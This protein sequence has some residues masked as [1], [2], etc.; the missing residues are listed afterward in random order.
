MKNYS[1]KYISV[2]VI[3]GVLFI[4]WGVL[5]L[6]DA[7]NYTYDGYYT[8]DNWEVIKVE[9]GSPAEISG[10]QLGD[11]I[12]STGG[13]AV[14]DTK[15]LNNR[16]RAEIGETREI[17]VDRNGEELKL[18]L[19][20]SKML[21]KDKTNNTVGFILGLIFILF[22][23][24]AS[25]KHKTSLS[26]S[27]GV[28]AVCFGFL[29][30]NGPYIASN[31]LSS[32]IGVISSVVFLFAFTAL[33]IYML[34]YPP[35]SS[36]LSSKNSKLLYIP[37]L[38][39]LLIIIGLEVIQPD[40]S[41]TLNMVMRLLFGVFIIGYFLIAL[42]TLIKKYSKAS[43]EEKSSNGLNLMLWGVIIGIV[44]ILIEFTIRTISPATEI[45][46]SDYL[47]YTFAAMPI[48]FTL[49]LS[50]LYANKTES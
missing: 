8:D 44:P 37:M 49:A 21:D 7:K 50:K 4:I 40:R 30:M 12:K 38:I 9:E 41:G 36:F 14:T 13:I 22:G 28:F 24:F 29:F 2:I 26:I 17:V 1:S 20:Y 45:P 32:I 39:L 48:C 5:G 43:S 18:Q 34:R 3:T 35:E 25:N 10:L 33:A 23:M 42:V 47:W 16:Q 11:V 19:T 6:M 15:A 27:F 46:G 31:I